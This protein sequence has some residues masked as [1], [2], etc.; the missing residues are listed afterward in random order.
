MKKTI[1]IFKVSIYNFLI[2]IFVLTPFKIFA[3][4]NENE[5]VLASKKL[6]IENVQQIKK[7]IRTK[8]GI[9]Y[10]G[11]CEEH[12]V[13]LFLIDNEKCSIKTLIELINQVIPEQSILIK[14]GGFEA[15]YKVCSDKDKMHLK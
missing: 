2:F 15:A 14:Q 8:E 11:Y 3:Q 1:K 7:I 5:I 9:V 4:E 12:Q 13:I 6:D 10:K